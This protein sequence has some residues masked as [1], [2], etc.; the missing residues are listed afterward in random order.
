MPCHWLA[1]GAQ[2]QQQL[3][4]LIIIQED[5]MVRLHLHLTGGW[6]GAGGRLLLLLPVTLN[7]V[8][9]IQVYLDVLLGV[10]HHLAG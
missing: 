9:I 8:S 3:A 6:C 7:R 5:D 4:A 1:R 2:N 10:W